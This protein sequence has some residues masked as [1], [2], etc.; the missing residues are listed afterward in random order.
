M[1]NQL[2][3]PVGGSLVLSVLVA[4]LPIATVLVALGVL[5][6]PAWQASLAGLVVGLIIAV[7]VWRFPLGLALDSRCGGRRVRAVAGDVDRVQC[8]AAL[9]HR[10]HFRALRRVPRLAAEPPA[11]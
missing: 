3:T 4:A 11:E 6:R 10:G 1:F 2:L 9:Q 8:P 5:R 7:A